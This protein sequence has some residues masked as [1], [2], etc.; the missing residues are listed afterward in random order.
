MAGL[1]VRGLVVSRYLL[2]LP[3]LTEVV[4][5]QLTTPVAEMTCVQSYANARIDCK[6]DEAAKSKLA[7][8]I[9]D[10]PWWSK[11]IANA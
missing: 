8:V 11:P 1:W 4:A 9:E 10:P 6:D 3:S 5:M 2:R 7:V